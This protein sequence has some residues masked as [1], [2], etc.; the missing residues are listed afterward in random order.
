MAKEPQFIEPKTWQAVEKA[1][2]AGL[3][4]SEAARRFGID[5][6][7]AIIMR[8][9][10]NRWP[11]QSRIVERAKA[12]QESVTER[13]TVTKAIRA[14][15]DKATE[16]LAQSWAEKGEQHRAMAFQMAHTALKRATEAPPAIEDS[17]DMERA[18]K[19]AR[20]AAGLDTAGSAVSNSF[21]FT[22][23]RERM[24]LENPATE[25][26]SENIR[27]LPE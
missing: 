15:N 19:M 10:R 12:L 7:H 27:E 11:V 18:D 13:A 26:L 17:A 24:V 14:A 4:Y 3:G 9:R 21:N 20:R 2:C 16:S 6:P 8:A 1:V 5:S 23:L 25:I 22:L